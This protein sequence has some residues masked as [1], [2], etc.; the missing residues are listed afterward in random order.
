METN[1]NGQRVTPFL[2]FNGKTEEAVNFYTSIIKNSKIV[3]L[4]RLGGNMATATFIL[5]G[6]EFMALDGGPQFTFSPA[7]SFFIKCSTQEEVD[8]LWEKLSE[9]GEKNRCGWLDDKFG[10]TWQIVPDALGQLLYTPNRV[11]SGNVMQA[12]LKMDKIII[13]DLQAAYDKE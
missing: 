4:Q 12:M 9:G 10:V 13:A 1:T 2:W 7:T 6:V 5:N 11:K 8:H 3:S